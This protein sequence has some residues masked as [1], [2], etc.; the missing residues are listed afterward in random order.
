M[1][2][3]AAAWAFEQDAPTSSAKFLLVAIASRTDSAGELQASQTELARLVQI[4]DR[5]V[6]TLL[7]ALEGAGLIIRKRNAGVGS[8]RVAD[9]IILPLA[10][11]EEISACVQPETISAGNRKSAPRQPEEISPATGKDFRRQP[12]EISAFEA[13]GNP[14][15]NIYK[16]P[17][18]I[19]PEPL[20][21]VSSVVDDVRAGASA[22]PAYELARIIVDRVNSP[23]LD[24]NKSQKLPRTA[25]RIHVWLEA[26]ADFDL[27]VLPTVTGVCKRMNGH[28]EQIE[29]W[30]YFDKAVRKATAQRKAAEQPMDLIL[31][32]QGPIHVDGT[33]NNRSNANGRGHQPRRSKLDDLLCQEFGGDFL[34]E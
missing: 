26:G 34:A 25:G 8:G 1:N 32:D 9:R 2:C 31:A 21:L 10:Q 4:S 20:E 22:K 3:A 23:W 5:Q 15:L 17:Q 14:P 6:R 18:E 28:G 30:S 27:D 12:E 13:T 7:K 33:R 29:S 24:P 16:T 19:Y 11:P